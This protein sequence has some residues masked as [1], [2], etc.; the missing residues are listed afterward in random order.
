[1]TTRPVLPPGAHVVRRDARTLLVGS[2]PGVVVPDRPGLVDVLRLLDGRSVESLTSLA[3]DRVPHFDGDVT[4][5]VQELLAR[6]ALVTVD[7][8]AARLTVRVLGRRGAHE[9]AAVV[10]AAVGHL[11][12]RESPVSSAL[13]LVSVGEPSRRWVHDAATDTVVLPV[14]LESRRARIG[15]LTVLGHTPCLDCFDTDQ[16]RWDP[17]WRAVLA[18][19]DRPLVS[20]STAR[21]STPLLW[22]TAALVA[23]QVQSLATGSDADSVGGVLLV[24]GSETIR[25]TVDFG[26]ACRC[27]P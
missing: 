6:G 5:T 8:P 25:R 2:G 26:P 22:H 19:L 7:R 12:L 24:D 4:A 3:A 16:A 21:P 11:G 10:D 27:L 20:A 18:Q 1:M 9:E 15:P 14:V 17:A 23:E 13:V